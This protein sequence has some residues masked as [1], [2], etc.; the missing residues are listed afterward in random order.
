MFKHAFK[1]ALAAAAILGVATVA[2]R[3]D[4]APAEDTGFPGDF[5]ATAIFTTN[6]SFRGITQTQDDPAIQGSFDWAHPIGFYAGAWASN[7]D[8]GDDPDDDANIEIDAYFGFASSINA[9]SYD[10]GAV[11]YI[12]PGAN[13]EGGEYNYWEIY[14][15]LGYDFGVAAVG[16]NIYYSPEF[17]GESGDTICYQGT[18]AIPLP[19]LPLE[20][21]LDAWVGYQDET[22]AFTDYIDYA[23]G[24]AVGVEGFTLDFRYVGTDLEEDECSAN[25]CDGTFI[26]TVSRSF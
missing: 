6:Y 24:I 16:A 18:V 5:S 7:I 13:D 25:T 21:S 17:F 22:D 2:A 9:F 26:F 12:Y 11:Y 15:K 23:V 19:F 1:T 8:F 3:A 20:T 4:E 10:L 14:G